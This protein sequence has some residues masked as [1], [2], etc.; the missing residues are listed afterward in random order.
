MVEYLKTNPVLHVMMAESVARGNADVLY[1]QPDGVMIYERPSNTHML[2]AGSAK[3]AREMLAQIENPSMLT[4]HDEFSLA[5]A[6][7]RYAFPNFMDCL[8]AAYFKKEIDPLPGDIRRLDLSHLAFV[9]AHYANVDNDKYVV[10]RLESGEM[11]GIYL[12]GE[13]AGFMGTH[14]E[15]SLGLLEILPAYR[16]RGLAEALERHVIREQLS[17][18]WTPFAQI[19]PD[20]KPS[21]ALHEKLGFA[22]SEEHLYWLF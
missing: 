15:G 1:D 9:R 8:N 20:N 2:A 14:E 12:N 10:G 5:E 21:L 11:Y 16:R 4:L 6:L 3:A 18:G 17:R 19:F 7:A 13:I 22:F